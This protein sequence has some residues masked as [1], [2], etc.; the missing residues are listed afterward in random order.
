M[1]ESED[2]A[3]PID[4][5][6]LKPA[7]R[8]AALRRAEADAEAQEASI[9][10]KKKRKKSSSNNLQGLH[11]QVQQQ[12]D[13]SQP[14]VAAAAAAH[15]PAAA[16]APKGI[17]IVNDEQ[18]NAQK[19]ELQKLLRAPRYFDEVY[20]PKG[21]ACWRCGKRG[22]LAKDC[23]LAAA[24]PCCYCAQYGH[25]PRDCPHSECVRLDRHVRGMSIHSVCLWVLHLTTAVPLPTAVMAACACLLPIC[26]QKSAD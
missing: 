13:G 5:L 11:D 8:L 7:K 2:N 15:Q 23:T 26:M 4:E 6:I 10:N 24:K 14:I 9:R 16:T 17:V 20:E 19:Y 12:I 1:S 3:N 22:H 25:E 18:A 21:V